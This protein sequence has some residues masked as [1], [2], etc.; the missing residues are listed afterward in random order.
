MG[1]PQKL[2]KL[3]SVYTTENLYII[4]KQKDNWKLSQ[5]SENPVPSLSF[6]SPLPYSKSKS[7]SKEQSP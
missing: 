2:L 4:K 7:T 1:E 6:D 3:F 5:A